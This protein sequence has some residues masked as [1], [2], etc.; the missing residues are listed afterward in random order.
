MYANLQLRKGGDYIGLP[1]T[2]VTTLVGAGEET[3]AIE[4]MLSCE[5]RINALVAN[6]HSPS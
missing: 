5:W 2:R 4:V 6:H 1:M 3:L